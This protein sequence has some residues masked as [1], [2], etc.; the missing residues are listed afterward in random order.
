MIGR[1]FLDLKGYCKLFYKDE[2]FKRAVALSD[3]WIDFGVWIAGL[4]C[5]AQ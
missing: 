1:L 2:I 4:K 3:A 5:R